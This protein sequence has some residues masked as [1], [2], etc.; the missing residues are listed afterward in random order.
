MESLDSTKEKLNERMNPYGLPRGQVVVVED[1][2]FVPEGESIAD[3]S[4]ES[5]F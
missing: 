2:L 1:S 4:D 3:D 5:D